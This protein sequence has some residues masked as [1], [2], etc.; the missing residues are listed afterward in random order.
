MQSREANIGVHSRCAM[1][2]KHGRHFVATPL[3]KQ[4]HLWWSNARRLSLVLPASVCG[5][6]QHWRLLDINV[7]VCGSCGALHVCDYPWGC[8]TVANEH[9]HEVCLVTGCI[10]KDLS[11]CSSEFVDTA[12]VAE[13]PAGG[14]SA[15]GH[16]GASDSAR[17]AFGE[18]AGAQD[19]MDRLYS[20]VYIYC[21]ELLYG[22]KWQE[23]MQ[24]EQEKVD[25]RRKLAFLRYLKNF[26]IQNPDRV[27]NLVL[28]TCSMLNH[29]PGMRSGPDTP[30]SSRRQLAA[31]CCETILR[32]IQ[33]LNH[34][35]P[36]LVTDVK[37]R[38]IVIGLLYQMRNGVVVHGIVVLP[39]C[40]LLSRVLPMEIFLGSVFGIRSKCITETENIIKTV[41]R[42]VDKVWL[43]SLCLLR[44]ALCGN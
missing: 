44:S 41:L 21:S 24:V 20:V 10:V 23:C 15:A 2:L 37:L 1:N 28:A 31:W 43:C 35:Q 4:L 19:C 9:G 32:H 25:T 36:N 27:P 39:R 34:L 40:A 13:R 18:P 7:A 22:G 8:E 5:H 3:Q 29:A 11:Y 12:S 38:N 26:K 17:D 42:V 6:Q 33:L 14:R 16:G 30:E